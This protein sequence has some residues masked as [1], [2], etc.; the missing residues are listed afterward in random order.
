M[1]G[2]TLGAVPPPAHAEEPDRFG[3]PAEAAAAV[4][5]GHAAD[6]PVTT[7]ADNAPGAAYGTGEPHR[8]SLRDPGTASPP[9]QERQPLGAAAPRAAPAASDPSDPARSTAGPA[10]WMDHAA[11]KTATGLALVV[12]ILLGLR[13]G[14]RRLAGG[15][16][17]LMAQLGA[18]GRAPSGLLEVLGRYPIA[19]GQTLVLLRLDRRIVLL[20]QTA[21]GFTPLSEITDADEVASILVKARDEEGASNAARFNALLREAERDPATADPAATEVDAVS[22]RRAAALPRAGL[23]IPGEGDDRRPLTGAETLRRRLGHLR[24]MVA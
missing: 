1:V 4:T 16:G 14:V 22:P 8:S 18:G 12:A 10:S 23:T 24:D 7:D 3:P 11:M 5:P 9:P 13:W 2:G 19:R 6:A 20:S 15:S 21:A 17:G